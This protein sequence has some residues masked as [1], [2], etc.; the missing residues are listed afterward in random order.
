MDIYTHVNMDSKREAA[1]KLETGFEQ[2]I[3]AI[4]MLERQQP[5][6]PV[7]APTIAKLLG[8]SESY[9]R[10]ITRKLVVAGLL[11]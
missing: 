10:K 11:S 8:T 5:G 2:S 1:M 4:V 6:V 7:K 3:Y 9:L